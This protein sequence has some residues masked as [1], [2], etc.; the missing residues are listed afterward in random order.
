MTGYDVI[1]DVHGCADELEELL[2]VLGYR[3]RGGVWR[4]PDRQAVFVGDLIDRGPRQVDTVTIARSMV[5]AGAGL[6]AMGNH[7]FNAIAWA[8]PDERNSGDYLRTHDGKKGQ[9]NRGQHAAFLEQVGEESPLHREMVEWFRTLPMRLDLGGLRVAHACWHEESLAV[10]PAVGDER[11][12]SVEFLH[13]AHDRS[14]AEYQAVETVLK[15]PEMPVPE[16]YLD[17][18]GHPRTNARVRW[19]DRSATT[20][21]G[22][23]EIPPNSTTKAGDPYPELADTPYPEAERFRYDGAVPVVFGHYWRR[24]PGPVVDAMAAC[25]DLSAVR[26]GHLAAYRWEG[27]PTLDASNLVTVSTTR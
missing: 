10:L 3:E 23:A 5:E 18:D 8:T 6:V 11:P 7:E 9:R 15:G 1:G 14:S 24:H 27:E 22:L 21:R 17:K 26:G 4:H 13:A 20:M 12:L 19:W 16:A 25:V 2:R